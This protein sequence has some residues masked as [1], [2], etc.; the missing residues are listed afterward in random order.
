MSQT[1]LLERSI[2]RH[3][4]I[5]SKRTRLLHAQ[6]AQNHF[7]GRKST[8]VLCARRS[9][10]FRAQHA[11]DTTKR[12]IATLSLLV[13]AAPRST[14][15][16]CMLL[17]AG[18]HEPTKEPCPNCIG[19][20]IA[21]QTSIQMHGTATGIGK[22][23]VNS[24]ATVLS[25]SD[26]CPTPGCA[27]YSAHTSGR[28]STTG[29]CL[30]AALRRVSCLRTAGHASPTPHRNSMNTK[31][32]LQTRGNEARRVRRVLREL[33]MPVLITGICG[34]CADV[35]ETKCAMHLDLARSNVNVCSSPGT[36]SI[37]PS[38]PG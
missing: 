4:P 32:N 14:K 5:L 24:R 38:R 26:L 7:L 12:T 33:R 18:A 30:S 16:A 15:H 11:G 34:S 27:P 29:R 25:C 13:T 9:T 17:S 2:E 36:R 6:N 37:R 8:R 23:A 1:D 35:S 19:G 20:A 28:L 31:I 21:R 10:F 22:Q 3:R